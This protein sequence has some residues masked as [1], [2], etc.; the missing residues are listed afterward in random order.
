V[1]RHL[2]VTGYSGIYH[3]GIII[4]VRTC[5]SGSSLL[6]VISGAYH[7]TTPLLRSQGILPTL[8]IVYVRCDLGVS[9]EVMASSFAQDRGG[10]QAGTRGA[11]HT[12]SRFED[13]STSI[14]IDAELGLGLEDSNSQPTVGEEWP[15]SVIMDIR[16]MEPD[17]DG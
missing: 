3:K 14:N 16:R 9:N 10:H 8:M 12:P 6:H 1:F 11:N 17:Q 5:Y 15:D 4:R 13:G 2:T 7:T